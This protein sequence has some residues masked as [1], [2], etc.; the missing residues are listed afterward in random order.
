MNAGLQQ[1]LQ[2]KQGR[3]LVYANYLDQSVRNVAAYARWLTSNRSSRK[4]DNEDSVASSWL[5][6][7][8]TYEL[9]SSFANPNWLGWC[10]GRLRKAPVILHHYRNM[11]RLEGLLQEWGAKDVLEFGSGFG[12]NLLLLQ[13][14]CSQDNQLSLSGFDYSDA[15]V[16]TSRA[17]VEH[18]GLNI[19]NLFLANGLT[20][21]IQD[22]S[23]DVVFSHYVIEQMR[24]RSL[25]C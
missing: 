17:T 5:G 2:A 4:V 18:F 12:V 11:L 25:R 16:L 15:R 21:P 20:L 23:F 7:S 14:M 19:R 9:I 22:N 13:K 6:Y 1:G 8:Q 24:A 10:D 3:A